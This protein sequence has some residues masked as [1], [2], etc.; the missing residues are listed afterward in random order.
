MIFLKI[1]TQLIGVEKNVLLDVWLSNTFLTSNYCLGTLYKRK[2][3]ATAW[4]KKLTVEMHRTMYAL[5]DILY[6]SNITALAL[7]FAAYED[8]ATLRN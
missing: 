1:S 8:P 4:L 6:A 2:V 3:I 7:T 5:D